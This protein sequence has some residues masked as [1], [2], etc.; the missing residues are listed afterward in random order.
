MGADEC[1]NY[2]TEDVNLKLKEYC[3][4][5]VDIYFDNVGGEIL[6]T[7]LLHVRDFCRI[8]M[9]GAISQYN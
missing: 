6:D 8:I 5:G 2:K 9:C 4:K 3:K 1:I 7:V